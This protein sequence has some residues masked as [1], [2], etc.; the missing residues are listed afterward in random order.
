VLPAFRSLRSR[1]YR[2]LLAGQG[3]C[4]IG[5][6]CQRIALIWLVYRTT[7]SPLLLGVAVFAGE[8]PYLFVAPFGG[9]LADRMDRRR[10][11]MV[12]QSVGASQ[13]FLLTA[14]VAIDWA[15]Y[16][17]LL[18]VTF[19]LGICMALENPLRQSMVPDL[20]RDPSDLP[21]AVA[22]VAFL[23]NGGRL[24]GPMIAGL[25]VGSFGERACFALAGLGYI[26]VVAAVA[27]I[28]LAPRASDGDT[29]PPLFEGLQDGAR[30][31][32]HFLP[33]RAALAVVAVVSFCGLPYLVLIPVYTREV[34]DAGARTLGYLL[35]A[36]GAGGVLGLLL[37]ALRTGIRGFPT[38]IALASL[39]AGAGL[40]L[41]AAVASFW[42]AL[43]AMVMI[44]AG[45][46]LAAT[47]A[48]IF[49]QSVATADK[50]GRI[51]GLFG[52]VYFGMAPVGSLVAGTLGDLMG[53]R[54]ALLLLGLTCVAC[55]SYYVRQLPHIRSALAAR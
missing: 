43:L 12:V 45:V 5:I 4:I 39:L 48:N 20:L 40:V 27:G 10:A 49:L 55:A 23:N 26:V 44:G 8:I 22:M 16:P 15:P 13:S 25:L 21:N 17:V 51:V 31:A 47:A 42:P 18:A 38:L 54:Q 53:S 50:R 33:I 52:M 34:L 36:A 2:L 30:Y 32:W 37:I 28:R 24:L 14:L 6:W 35:S 3:V 29:H 46:V 9:L 1:D 19:V 11:L 7:G 41:C